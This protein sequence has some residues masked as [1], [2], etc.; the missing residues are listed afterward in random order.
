MKFVIKTIVCIVAS[1][2]FYFL[3][4]YL[5]PIVSEIRLTFY[6]SIAIIFLVSL[7]GDIWRGFDYDYN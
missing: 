3:A 6:Q 1:I 5:L 7:L 2:A 4:N